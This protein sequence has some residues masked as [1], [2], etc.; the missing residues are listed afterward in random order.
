MI[1]QLLDRLIKLHRIT[2]ITSDISYG[3]IP[4]KPLARTYADRMLVIGDAAAYL[5]DGM[6]VSLSIYNQTP[7]A[8]ELKCVAALPRKD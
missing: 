6:S 3:S 8:I 4:L 1:V 7:I 2:S 5:Q